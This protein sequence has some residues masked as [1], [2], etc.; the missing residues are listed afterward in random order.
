VNRSLYWKITIPFVLL[1]LVSM[2]VLGF[3]TVNMVRNTQMDQLRSYLLNEARLVADEALP[4]M[5]NS[6]NNSNAD[7][8]AKTTGREI[9]SRVTIIAVDGTVLGDS[10]E[11]PSTMENHAARP[12]IA[13]ALAT[14]SG[15]ITR[16]STTTSQNMLYMAVRIADH[17][18]SLGVAR[19][20]LPITTVEQSVSNVIRTI[21]WATAIAA[22]LVIL[23]AALI[24]R[25][26]TRPVRKLT[27]AAVRLT[28]GQFDQLIQ[29]ESR[30]EIGRLGHAF[31]KMSANLRDKMAAVSDEKS[32]LATILS[33]ITDGVIMTDAR[34][35]I[36]LA[37]PAAG[38]LFNFKESQ[39]LGKPLIEA[40]F[41]HEIDQLLKKCLDVKEKQIATVDTTNGKFLRVIAV[42]L[43]TESLTG[44]LILLQDLTELRNLQTMRREFVGNISHELRT[45]LAGIKAIV[46]TLQDGAIDDKD[47]ARDFLGKVNMEV[48]NLTQMVNELIELSRIET[49]KVKLDLATVNLNML[50]NEVIERL[51]PLSERKQITIL[52]NLSGTLP[53]VQADRERIQQVIINIMHNAIKFTPDSGEI[54]VST[55]A[56]TESVTVR[57]TD[58]GIGISKEDLAHIFERF[59]KADRSRSNPGSGLGLA[60]A[61]H[62]VKA[63]G[64]DISVQSQV[65]KGST[66]SFSL[67]LFD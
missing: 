32:K 61:K 63:H 19:V 13:A 23:A 30:D 4:V 29:M 54:K 39:A 57:I 44:A 31:N 36:L 33:S 34:S 3:Y 7:E 52:T 2:G 6:G 20:A 65:G 16:Y 10:W 40:V 26:I 66:F 43:K 18:H 24:T 9:E 1:I 45:P 58:T 51:K 38:S 50:I 49:G 8:I 12:E 64:G 5:I 56:D 55:E 37:N 53:T 28:S 35:N 41:N 48:D 17:E 62:V 47:V 14:G 25:M 60:I 59:F 11:N 21:S 15:E 42:P 22:L 27:R 46:E 67:P